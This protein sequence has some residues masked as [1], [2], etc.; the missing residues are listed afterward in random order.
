VAW[1][2]NHSYRATGGDAN[3]E[4]ENISRASGGG[5]VHNGGGMAGSESCLINC[6]FSVGD[7]GAMANNASALYLC[8][9]LRSP[10][11]H[12]ASHVA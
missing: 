4:R 2:R 11:L 10:L 7:S 9:L 1:A 5:G 12:R 6:I 3:E 8:R